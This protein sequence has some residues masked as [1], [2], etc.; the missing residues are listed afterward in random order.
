MVG[1]G[2]DMVGSGCGEEQEGRVELDF[3][4]TSEALDRSYGWRLKVGDEIFQTWPVH[5]LPSKLPHL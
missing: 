1:A 5:I 3:R 2:L 4:L